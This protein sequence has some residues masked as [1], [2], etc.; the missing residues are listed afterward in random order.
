MD[1]V[2]EYPIRAA[3]KALTATYRFSLIILFIA[4]LACSIGSRLGHSREVVWIVAVWIFARTL[5]FAVTNNVETRYMAA[6]TPGMELVVVIGVA[7]LLFP[8]RQT[9]S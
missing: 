3:T 8:K 2:L 7:A 6:A 4:I 1:I 5:F 9:T